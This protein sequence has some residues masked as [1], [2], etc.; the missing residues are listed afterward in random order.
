[1]AARI[2]TESRFSNETKINRP[3]SDPTCYCSFSEHES[4]R[5]ARGF[6]MIMTFGDVGVPSPIRI[7]YYL[8]LPLLSFAWVAREI[9]ESEF[10]KSDTSGSSL[11]HI[12]KSSQ[13]K[14]ILNTPHTNTK[15][16]SAD[17][18]YFNY[19]ITTTASSTSSSQP[20]SRRWQTRRIGKPSRGTGKTFAT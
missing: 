9:S 3:H 10:G 4:E 6:S 13:V 18:L 12:L 17:K 1:M 16:R 8:M 20:N 2:G 5:R 15:P 7:S 11:T 14:L 19:A